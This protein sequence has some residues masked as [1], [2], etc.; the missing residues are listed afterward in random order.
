MW[1]IICPRFGRWFLTLLSV[2]CKI[3]IDM[4]NAYCNWWVFHPTQYQDVPE[5]L[6]LKN[7]CLS[8]WL[9]F[10]EK[11]LNEFWFRI[12]T[13]ISRNCWSCPNYISAFLYYIL[14]WNGMLNIKYYKIKISMN[15]EKHWW[16]YLTVSNN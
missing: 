15:D 11:S 5:C 3:C 10:H 1:I 16:W 6:I 7:C 12:R 9:G 4:F 2:W 14:I 13:G 8:C